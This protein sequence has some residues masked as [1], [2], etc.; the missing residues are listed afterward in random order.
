MVIKC[1]FMSHKFSFFFLTKLQKTKSKLEAKKYV[2]DQIKMLKNRVGPLKMTV[3]SSVLWKLL[4]QLAKKWPE[5][6]LKCLT[7]RVVRFISDQSLVW[8]EWPYLS[9]AFWAERVS[10]YAIDD[11]NIPT[12]NMHVKHRMARCQE[13]QPWWSYRAKSEENCHVPVR[14]TARLLHSI[15]SSGDAC[16]HT[17]YILGQ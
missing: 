3:R 17:T 10:C 9:K 4:M 8:L 13:S 14:V 1:P 12:R 2:S 11:L 7:P 6:V 15:L 5:T 16:L